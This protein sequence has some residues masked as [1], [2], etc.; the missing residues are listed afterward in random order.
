MTEGAIVVSFTFA[1]HMDPVFV[2]VL[3]VST[4]DGF[5]PFLSPYTVSA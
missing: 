3:A 2:P 5:E 4:K 1:R